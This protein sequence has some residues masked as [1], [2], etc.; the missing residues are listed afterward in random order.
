MFDVH[1]PAPNG[2]QDPTWI[3][4]VRDLP[5]DRAPALFIVDNDRTTLIGKRLRQVLEA[6]QKGPIFCASPVRLSDAVL[7]LRRDY[8]VRIET[9]TTQDGRKFYDLKSTA[10][11]AAQEAA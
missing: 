1:T 9:E 4:A 11:R 7:I 8:G 6:L 2:N 5:Q 3:M 10:T